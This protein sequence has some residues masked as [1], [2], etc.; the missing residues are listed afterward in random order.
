MYKN[1]SEPTNFKQSGIE[2]FPL[3]REYII[4]DSTVYN[5]LYGVPYALKF[6]RDETFEDG[7]FSI[8]SQFLFSRIPCSFDSHLDHCT[9]AQ[10]KFSR[11]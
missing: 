6:L 1:L 11:A 2:R 5:I 3:L 8:F 10:P 9:R 7:Q 4:R